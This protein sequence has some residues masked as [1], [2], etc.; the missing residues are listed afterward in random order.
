MGNNDI[1]KRVLQNSIICKKKI[2][3]EYPG[4]MVYGELGRFPLEIY[5][6][7]RIINYWGKLLT[8]KQEKNPAIFHS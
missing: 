2:I 1:V 4:F 6:Q 5:L 8:G 7:L 3:E